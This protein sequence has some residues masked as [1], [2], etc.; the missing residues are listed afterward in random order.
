MY[1]FVLIFLTRL[2][3]T[4]KFIY[5]YTYIYKYFISKITFEINYS[6]IKLEINQINYSKIKFEINRRFGIVPSSGC[7]SAYVF[8]LPLDHEFTDADIY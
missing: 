2:S 7:V 5:I 8:G 1:S 3:V 4:N 6:K